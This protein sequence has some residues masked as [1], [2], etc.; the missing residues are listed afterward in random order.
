MVATMTSKAYGP[1]WM[2]W[3]TL[4]LVSVHGDTILSQSGTLFFLSALMYKLMMVADRNEDRVIRTMFKQKN[5][6]SNAHARTNTRQTVAQHN[7]QA[8]STAHTYTIY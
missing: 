4:L 3:P 6:P 8:A 5:A 2:P 1:A 7:A